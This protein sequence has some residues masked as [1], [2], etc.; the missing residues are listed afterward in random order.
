MSRG[1][2]LV[3]AK[4]GLLGWLMGM[5]LSIGENTVSAGCPVLKEDTE[6]IFQLPCF[7]ILTGKTS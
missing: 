4:G 3:V 1:W 7:F 2:D 5:L 6:I